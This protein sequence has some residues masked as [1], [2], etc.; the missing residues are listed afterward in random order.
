MNDEELREMA[1]RAMGLTIGEMLYFN[2]L[3]CDRQT[4]EV[5]QA[6]ML[7]ISIDSFKKQTVITKVDADGGHV[8]LLIEQHDVHNH[9]SARA[10][11]YAV[12]R[13]AAAIGIV[14]PVIVREPPVVIL[15]TIRVKEST[16]KHGRRIT[17]AKVRETAIA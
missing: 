15:N 4:L 10:T 5:A 14:G 9:N 2:P 6:L 17:R 16:Y 13:A 11:R 12:L 8:Q 7:N 1:A 3:I